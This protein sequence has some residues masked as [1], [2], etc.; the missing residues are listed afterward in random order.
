M[1]ISIDTSIKPREPKI[2]F[3]SSIFCPIQT[4]RMTKVALGTLLA[5]LQL[6]RI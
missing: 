6:K 1:F 3:R 2:L 5:M 4:L